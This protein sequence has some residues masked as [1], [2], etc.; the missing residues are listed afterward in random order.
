M[1]RS[2]NLPEGSSDKI[3]DILETVKLFKDGRVSVRVTNEVVSWGKVV[4]L[5]RCPLYLVNPQ[6][7]PLMSISLT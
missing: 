5:R 4:W 3:L 7:L 2:S 6:V 1:S